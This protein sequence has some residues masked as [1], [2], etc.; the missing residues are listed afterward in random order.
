MEG[1]YL[2][3]RR[4]GSGKGISRATQMLTSRGCPYQCVF[5]ASSAFWQKIRFFSAKRVVEEIKLLYEKYKV[6][7]ITVYDDL[8]PANLERLR[9]IVELLEKENLL[10]KINFIC[11]SRVNLMDDERCRLL[12]KMGVDSI[13]LG[14]ESGSQKVL[15]YLKNDTTTVEQNKKAIEVAKRYG[16]QVHG[17]FMIGSPN[18]TKED[19]LETLKFI[20][21]NPINSVEIA[22]VTPLP[23]T[24]LWEYAKK[25]GLV[26]DNMNVKKLNMHPQ[27]KDF[28][29]L[30]EHMSREE[31]LK[32][33]NLFWKET[34]NL[35][36]TVKFKISYLLSPFIWN[37]I[38]KHP[39]KA[40]K[41][42]YYSIVKKAI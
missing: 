18:E 31:F 2:K 24:R 15:S 12:K 17:F 11:L 39:S 14:F 20:K 13:G 23:G 29:F 4:A 38:I 25:R 3:P 37:K 16:F 22:S 28:I 36:Y 9:D 5:C 1:Y 27:S 8:F 42:F 33:Y 19:M 34:D 7:E 30:N 35:T 21:E 32:M 6:E 26:N 10:G 40:M 41:Y